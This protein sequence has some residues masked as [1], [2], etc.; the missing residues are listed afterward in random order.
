[1]TGAPA[2]RTT[3]M[4]DAEISALLEQAADRGARLA[5]ERLGLHDTE[6]GNDI[7]DLRILIDGWREVK[8]TIAKAVLQWFTIGVLGLLTLGMWMQFG[9]KK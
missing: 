6:A 9:G 4:S 5:L 8:T 7:R 3:A 2:P 1:M